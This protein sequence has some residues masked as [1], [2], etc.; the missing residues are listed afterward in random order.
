MLQAAAEA[1]GGSLAEFD[2]IGDVKTINEKG[3]RVT[4]R[5]ERALLDLTDKENL[6]FR[7]VL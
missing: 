7:Y 3:D 6:A 1:S 5:V 2:D 4:M